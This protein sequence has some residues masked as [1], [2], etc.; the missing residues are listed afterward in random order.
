METK[1]F[2]IVE[3]IENNPI[4]KL[5]N[6]YNVKMLVK[7]K[8]QFTEFEQQLFLSSFYCYFNYHS[9][10]DYIIDLDNVWKWLG[11]VAKCKAKTLLEKYFVI[12]KDYKKSLHDSVKRTNSIKGGQNK[13]IFM[14]NIKT[15]KL[16]CIKAETKK[17]DEIHEYFLKMEQIIQEVVHEESNELK[18]Q[19]QIKNDE[20]AEKENIIFGLKEREVEIKEK[21]REKFL[22]EKYQNGGHIIYIIKVALREN[23]CYI[24]K[25]GKSEIGIKGRYEECQKFYGGNVL[26]LDCFNVLYCKEFETK[27]HDHFRSSRVKDLKDHEQRNELFLVGKEITYAMIVNFIKK[28]IKAY[29]H[30]IDYFYEENQKL[31]QQ[32]TEL[33]QIIENQKTQPPLSQ[34]HP[35]VQPSQYSMDQIMNKLQQMENIILEKYNSPQLQSQ[36]QFQQKITTNLGI[37]L[38]TLGPRLQKIN[39]DTLTIIKVYETVTECIQ[40]YNNKIKRPSINKAVAENTIY[41]S[42]RWLLVERD[43]DPNIIHHIEPTKE[44]KVQ[45]IGYIAKL[46]I[47]KTEI[48]TVYLDKKTA[49]IL[50]GNVSASALDNPVKNQSLCHGYYYMLYDECDEDIKND[51]M[52][53]INGQPLL[54]KDG[55]GIGQYDSKHN[56]IKEFRC[57]FDCI[58]QTPF[59]IGEKTL[60]KVLNKNII[61]QNLYYF[62]TMKEKLYLETQRYVKDCDIVL[63][64][65]LK[66]R[67]REDYIAQFIRDKII[68]EENGKITKTELTSEFNSWYSSTVGKGGP[69]AKEVHEYMDKKI[70]KFKT[71][72]G[73]WVGASIRYERKII[74]HL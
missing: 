66:Y 31:K 67:E 22:L 49:S 57:K 69:S 43:L 3:L 15:F 29:E 39:P 41:R 70:G 20:I 26:L 33:N 11:F 51:F 13:E 32:I 14:L 61:Y 9:T 28:S 7:I 65:S 62:K 72:A 68:I 44:I 6:D 50:N 38:P 64:S 23:G 73:A 55:I 53:K 1:Q 60:A 10:S 34:T 12:D 2:D 71:A 59:L 27:I 16:F 25:I 18:N 42:F 47:E 35:S 24:V 63:G 37:P 4:T 17:A 48:I 74:L 58:K 46:N 40:E 8:E 19:L 30:S 21:E 45:H 36:P 56:L 54:Y 5:S 52:E